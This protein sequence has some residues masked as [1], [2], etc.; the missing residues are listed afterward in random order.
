M[1]LPRRKRF[2]IATIAALP[3]LIALAIEIRNRVRRPTISLITGAVI[4]AQD[5]V[6]L[7]R[8]ISDVKVLAS[9][10]GITG[11]SATEVSGLFRLKFDPPLPAGE[12][13]Q[14]T[15]TH[16]DYRTFVTSVPASQEVLI[17]RLTPA[18]P[19]SRAG[20]GERKSQSI[21]NIRIRYTTSSSMTTI[22]GTAVRTF[23]VRN[24]AN[25]PCDRQT[26]CSPDHRWKATVDSLTLDAGDQKQFRN[27]RVS[28]IA[29][30]CPFSALESDRFSRGGRVITVSVKNWAD[31]VTYLVEAEVFQTAQSEMV[32]YTYPAI[33]GRSMNF[34]LPPD[35]SGLSI[36]CDFHGSPI[37]FPLGPQL[38][39]SWAK[40]RSETGRDGSKQVRCQL[41]PGYRF[42]EK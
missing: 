31:P 11:E 15:V 30:P 26:P 24:K 29:G 23:T 36:E 21:S 20:A 41:E 39:L 33:F 22:A 2:I 38:R 37:V 8:P 42:T 34:T 7:Q 9:A 28:C 16:P 32:R 14:L 35:A 17:V 19:V 6:E 10:R 18:P 1:F 13:V 12:P 4:A 40:C 5:D 27:V 3:I 25:V